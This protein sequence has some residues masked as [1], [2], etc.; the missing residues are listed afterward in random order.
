MSSDQR[1]ITQLYDPFRF[2]VLSFLSFSFFLSL[3]LLF[4]L[5]TN[6]AIIS[7][8]PNVTT[9]ANLER[10]IIASFATDKP[11]GPLE[12]PYGGAVNAGLSTI[13]ESSGQLTK[14]VGLESGSMYI[15]NNMF[16]VLATAPKVSEENLKS[17]HLNRGKQTF[18][19]FL[20]SS[21]SL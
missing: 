19:T 4:F 21:F 3:S 15:H 10:V 17:N 13:K 16:P 2:V 20:S 6:Q 5:R 7:L 14:D 18:P 9:Q 8:V 12:I 1:N 11:D